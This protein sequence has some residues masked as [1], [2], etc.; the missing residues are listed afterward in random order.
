M[1]IDVLKDNEMLPSENGERAE[2]LE[3]SQPNETNGERGELENGHNGDEFF[4]LENNSEKKPVGKSDTPKLLAAVAAVAVG[5]VAV[6]A[7]L[8]N[9]P[10]YREPVILEYREGYYD[11]GL[12]DDYTDD[13]YVNPSY[14]IEFSFE[15]AGYE[16]ESITIT[17]ESYYEQP[18]IDGARPELEPTPIE[19]TVLAEDL[20][21]E[22]TGIV[23]IVYTVEDAYQIYNLTPILNYLT[24]DGIKSVE[25]ESFKAAVPRLQAPE[26]TETGSVTASVGDDEI[27]FKVV[28]DAYA[29]GCFD[30]KTES[31]TVYY[32]GEEIVYD[33]NT[34]PPVPD[35]VN[36]KAEFTVTLPRPAEGSDWGESAYF[37][38]SLV[39]DSYF[40]GEKMNLDSHTFV[41]HELI[42]GEA[43]SADKISFDIESPSLAAA[44]LRVTDVKYY[45]D[46]NGYRDSVDKIMPGKTVYL[47]VI[48]T[49]SAE[50][51]GY[52]S[53]DVTANLDKLP[54]FDTS[55]AER[56]ELYPGEERVYLDL[57]FTMPSENVTSEDIII[58]SLKFE[59]I[60]VS[61]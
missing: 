18:E 38:A 3:L 10:S 20:D 5:T 28:F 12:P 49:G 16:A 15:L 42:F 14:D 53:L 58:N 51:R 52:I 23:K 41:G 30:F 9:L 46:Y 55:Y 4:K 21:A 60:T 27:E 36:E 47:T 39:G 48:L 2:N 50:S 13:I 11:E 56:Y 59:P 26:M 35:I 22:E 61:N 25:G 54:D 45:T 8:V 44:G 37:E 29:D 33:R 40:N 7:S 19:Y 6:A 24:E 43:Y 57:T 31:L 34:S 32:M 17:G 1:T